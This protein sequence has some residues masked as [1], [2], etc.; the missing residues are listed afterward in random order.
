MLAQESARPPRTAPSLVVPIST[1][2]PRSRQVVL[3]GPSLPQTCCAS[4]GYGATSPLT[5][6]HGAES[7]PSLAA[8]TPPQPDPSLRRGACLPARSTHPRGG[9]L[10]SITAKCVGPILV[11]TGSTPKLSGSRCKTSAHPRVRGRDFA[12]YGQQE[13]NRG[14]SLCTGCGTFVPHLAVMELFSPSLVSRRRP[15]P[16]LIQ[17]LRRQ[18]CGPPPTT[19]PLYRAGRRSWWSPLGGVLT[20]PFA[21]GR[22]TTLSA[23]IAEMPDPSFCTGAG[24]PLDRQVPPILR[25]IPVRAGRVGPAGVLVQSP[26]HPRMRGRDVQLAERGML[27]LGSSPYAWAGPSW[28]GVF[29]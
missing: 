20:H 7:D 27:Q 1:R 16:S 9:A 5:I 11:R 6:A 23:W 29:R 10:V 14:S 2:G 13:W 28:P 26:A 12:S 4:C 15:G 22:D 3:D 17:T 8:N 24:R 21:Q 25:L 19:H 18:G